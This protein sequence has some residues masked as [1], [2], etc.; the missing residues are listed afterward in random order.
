MHLVP[1]A[2]AHPHAREL[3]QMSRVLDQLHGAVERIHA[4]VLCRE[5]RTALPQKGREGMT[6]EQILRALV[7][8]Q[9]NRFS[10]EEL[11]FHLADSSTY[12]T[13]Y[14]FGI[15]R[16]APSKSTL[17]R[18][19]KRVTV[20]TWES[21]NRQLLLY[22]SA[23]GVERGEKARTD[24]TV[25]ASNIHH[26]TD[27]SLLWDCVRV[28][29]RQMGQA[30]THFGLAFTDRRRRAK[31]RALG[32]LNAKSNAQRVPLYRDLLRV[33]D[34]TVRQ[35]ERLADE[36]D[37]GAAT[38]GMDLLRA[39]ALADQLRHHV[40][41]AKRVLD[42]TKRR[43][44]AGESVPASEKLVAI[45]ETHT[46]I[47][48]KDRRETLYGHKVCLPGGASGLIT[49]IVVEQGSPADATLTVP[50]MQRQRDLY[51]KPPRQAS[52]DGAFA[53]KKNLADLKALGIT[54]VAFSKRGSLAITDMVKSTW[55]YRRLRN[56]RAGVEATISFLKRTFGLDCC[57][58]SGFGSFK[59]Y[60]LASVLA[61]NLRLM[62]RLTLAG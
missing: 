60:V 61:C 46:D 18:N 9:M 57:A 38:N 8:K 21:L 50:M 23:K 59:A 29:T 5:T 43:V 11:A 19:L 55:V 37:Q 41:L 48:V 16:Q 53:S 1:T 32:I 28:L 10:Y 22:A 26:P 17:Q 36:L 2:I 6:A 25:V 49:D 33:T 54:D 20:T 35:A 30:Q 52:F 7:V 12:R 45:F 15:D 58:W 24:C 14:R 34:K 42:Q 13:F 4:D 62:A 56:F 3:L 47:I 27:S 39:G 51:G 31:R 40:G 44:L